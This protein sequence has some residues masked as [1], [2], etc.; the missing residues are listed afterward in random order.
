MI[1]GISLSNQL[2]MRE[3]VGLDP[4]SGMSVWGF[5]MLFV[6]LGVVVTLDPAICPGQRRAGAVEIW[7][8][9]T[10]SLPQLA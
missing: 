10:H 4:I 7:P 9:A 5:G 3:C 8:A 2:G 1:C 6:I